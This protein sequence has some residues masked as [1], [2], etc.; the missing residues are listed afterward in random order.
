MARGI[1]TRDRSLSDVMGAARPAWAKLTPEAIARWPP[2]KRAELE[3]WMQ[4]R[5]EVQGIPPK[6]VAWPT[7]DP[8]RLLRQV[9][10]N[11]AT[12]PL[13]PHHQE[14]WE[15][16]Y[17]LQPGVRP[18]PFVGIWP[19]GGAKTSSVQLGMALAGAHRRRRYCLYVTRTQKQADDKITDFGAIFTNPAFAMRYPDMARRK[20]LTVTTGAGRSRSGEWNRVRIRTAAGFTIEGIGLDVAARGIK[21][22]DQRP[23]VLIF[24]DIDDEGDNP[25]KVGKLLSTMR[26]AL[27]PAGS[28][29]V[30]IV[31]INNLVHDN[32]VASHLAYPGR[33]PEAERLLLNR[34]LSG[35]VPAVLDLEVEYRDDAGDGEP[36]YVITR[37][38]P[39]WAGFDL[40]AA[41][42]ALNASNLQEYKVEYQHETEPEGE[43]FKHIEWELCDLDEVPWG[44]LV[45]VETWVDPATSDTDRSDSMGISCAGVTQDG[46]VWV[47]Y[48]WE[49]ITSPT[50]ALKQALRISR[51]YG[52]S[53]LGIETDTGGDAWYSVAREALRELIEDGEIPADWSIDLD[54]AKAGQTQKSKHERIKMLVTPFER[55]RITIVRG[56]H[57]TLIRGLKRFPGK[58]LDGVDAFWWC[59][60]KLQEVASQKRPQAK[61][62]AQVRRPEWRPRQRR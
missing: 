8:F 31:A 30:A 26:R 61:T 32:S 43:D 14:W 18:R 47:L 2:D 56:T 37:G 12:A 5:A 33:F 1:P 13:A 55:K 10:P 7:S 34:K 22:E 42:N 17:A 20:V 4:R 50:E 28:A 16:V 9:A 57:A 60:R 29:D 27:I 44:Q 53:V 58:P 23:D 45:R 48:S 49:R 40:T 24:D 6:P 52:A 59:H 62:R 19:R 51:E 35:P 25:G 21:M 54:S 38:T 46:R 41:Q 11:Y 3:A 36:G 15:W 39:A